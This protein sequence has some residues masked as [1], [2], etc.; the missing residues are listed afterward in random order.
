MTYRD[1]RDADQARIAALEGE[2]AAAKDRIDEL[3]GKQSQALVLASAS[4]L[5]ARDSSPAAAKWFGAPT[6]LELTRKF[7][8]AF[9]VDKL[10]DLVD[11]IREH[12]RQRG[13][14]ELLRSSVTWAAERRGTGPFTMVTVSVRDNVTTLLVSDEL[15]QL[16]GAV[17][18]GVGGGV[19]GSLIVAPIFASIAMPMLT[20]V[21]VAGWLGG[22]FGLTRTIFKSAAKRRAIALQRVFDAVGAEI[23]KKLRAAP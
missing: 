18:G 22:F 3:E 16:A 7:D 5:A 12:T 17:Y 6:R 11:T 23:E 10:E 19:G 1:D 21:F 13:R 15:G 2:L 20:P 4:A 9:P 14:V 8:G